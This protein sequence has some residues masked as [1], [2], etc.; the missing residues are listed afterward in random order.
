L[1]LPVWG[2]DRLEEAYKILKER[3]DL[4]YHYTIDIYTKEPFLEITNKFTNKKD[5]LKFLKD[6]LQAD[7]LIVLGDNLNDLPMFEISNYCY[8]VENADILVK[9]AATRVIES[10]VNNGV[11]KFL[12]KY[13]NGEM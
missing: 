9:Q 4:C 10:N 12:E 8:A 6:Y 5:S 3:Y 13:F 1:L 11:A 2:G 7:E